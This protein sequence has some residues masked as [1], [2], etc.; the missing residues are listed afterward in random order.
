MKGN[1]IR[2]E[3]KTRLMVKE[4][5]MRAKDSFK[6]NQRETLWKWSLQVL[7]KILTNRQSCFSIRSLQ[8]ILNQSKVKFL[9]FTKM[10]WQNLTKIYLSKYFLRRLVMRRNIQVFILTSSNL[11]QQKLQSLKIE[12]IFLRSF[13]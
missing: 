5:A 2:E 10:P 1:I 9:K 7:K 13:N 8:T 11:S 6:F 3:M 12:V 4:S